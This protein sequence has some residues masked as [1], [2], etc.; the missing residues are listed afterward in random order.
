MRLDGEAWRTLFDSYR[1]EAFRLETLPAYQ[2]TGE[3]AEYEHFQATGSV[4]IPYEDPWLVRVRQFRRSGR[5]IGRVHVID[6]PLTDYLRYELAVYRYTVD[7]GEDVRILDLAEQP[8]PGMPREDFWLFDDT[9]VVRMDYGAD[10]NQLGRELLEDADPA[11]YVRW[12]R[13]ALSH[14]QPFKEYEAKR[15]R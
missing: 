4:D 15:A 1:R 12:K 8:D 5:W 10:G 7:A 14:A 6:G 2:V 11:A 9:A 3:R 13:L